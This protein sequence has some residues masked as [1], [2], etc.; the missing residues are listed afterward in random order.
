MKPEIKKWK[1]IYRNW[2]KSGLSRREFCRQN[3]L[4]ISTFH[5]WQ[6]RFKENDEKITLNGTGDLVKIPNGATKV[7]AEF[8]EL[9][10]PGGCKLHI[11]QNSQS[12]E[13]KAIISD[14]REVLS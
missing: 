7:K 10:F 8:F 3:Q 6:K 13:R 5:F 4:A 1:R 9:E 11:P 14:L 12:S 2:E